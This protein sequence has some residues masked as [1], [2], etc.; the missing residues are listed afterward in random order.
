MNE[1]KTNQYAVLLS[2]VEIGVG[3]F[4]HAFH[5]PLSGQLLS[6]HQ[7][8]LMTLAT[9]DSPDRWV[10]FKL[11]VYAGLM[12]MGLGQGKKIVPMIAI[13]AQGFLFALG[14]IVGRSVYI[15][16]MLASVWALVQPF[17]I[18]QF[19][20]WG[21]AGDLLAFYVDKAT[22]IGV[23]VVS[24]FLFFVSLKLILA[25]AACF[26]AVKFGSHSEG[27]Y[28]G[29]QRR[30]PVAQRPPK[31]MGQEIF[32]PLFMIS[33]SILIFYYWKTQPEDFYFLVA[34]A[35]GLALLGGALSRFL[36][37]VVSV[38]SSPAFLQVGH[39]ILKK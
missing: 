35:L 9:K 21:E 7:I 19:L 38:R 16:A 20:S 28:E 33:F 34:R 3:S 1:I 39:H 24:I 26:F 31:S 5:I 17:L 12:K 18:F 32:R 13:S 11:S 6:L 15:G 30:F 27:F 25:V 4:L 22:S 8:F 36:F 14:S 23:P 29:I 2:I 37:S 10:S